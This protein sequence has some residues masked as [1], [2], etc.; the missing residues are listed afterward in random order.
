[1]DEQGLFN[2]L[3]GGHAR[4][5]RQNGVLKDTLNL[6]TYVSESTT[7]CPGKILIQKMDGS[8]VR[9]VETENTASQSRFPA[10]RFSNQTKDLSLGQAKGHSF[11]SSVANRSAP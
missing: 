9:F 8:R 2:D 11:H 3:I 1:M 10:A 7:S 6:A 4:I 5:Q